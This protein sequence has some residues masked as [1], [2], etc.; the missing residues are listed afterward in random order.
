MKLYFSVYWCLLS[1]TWILLNSTGIH[2]PASP[3]FAGKGS[4]QDFQRIPFGQWG[5]FASTESY[6][7]LGVFCYLKNSL[8]NDWCRSAEGR[9]LCWEVGQTLRCNILMQNFSQN[10]AAAGDSLDCFPSSVC[11]PMSLLVVPGNT[12]WQSTSSQ[13]L[14]SGANS[15]RNCLTTLLRG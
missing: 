7:L 8:T 12:F 10:Q 15:G 4:H 3:C 14:T 11:L 6:K 5:Y 13:I 9:P 1:F 2:P